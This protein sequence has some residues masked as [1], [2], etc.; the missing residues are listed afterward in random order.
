[1]ASIQRFED[2]E[3]W[4][5][6]RKLCQDI[7]DVISIEP[8]SKDYKLKEQINGASGSIMDNIAEG[9][10][11]G[12]NAEFIQFLIIAKG[13]AGEVRSQLF[14]IFDRAY[15][16]EVRF[17]EL[18]SLVEEISKRIANFINYLRNSEHK[19]WTRRKASNP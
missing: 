16:T 17:N 15:I 9:F 11:R 5:L 10:E 7:F 18:K 4:Q 19:G 3:I 8:L 6:A 14:R 2:L 13:S 1:M 12:G